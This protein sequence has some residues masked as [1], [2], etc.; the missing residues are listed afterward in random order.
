MSSM[1]LLP[2]IVGTP[3]VIKSSIIISVLAMLWEKLGLLMTVSLLLSNNI[4]L[5]VLILFFG[6]MTGLLVLKLLG[7]PLLFVVDGLKH[8][9]S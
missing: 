6:Q 5:L 2:L 8:W 3:I 4:A 7:L 9:E 1:Y